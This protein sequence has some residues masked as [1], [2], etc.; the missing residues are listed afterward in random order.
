MRW[1]KTFLGTAEPYAAAL[2]RIAA[3]RWVVVDVETSGLD[4]SSDALLAIGAVA[5]R[6]QRVVVEDSF[7]RVVRQ[8]RASSRGNILIH[9]IGEQA[10]LG[11]MDAAEACR[12]FLD[13]AGPSPLV[14]FH[15]GF[16]RAFLARSVKLWLGLPLT[17]EWLDLAALAPALNP[18]VKAKALD[19]WLEHFGLSVDQ[20]HQASA[21]A[22]ATA[23]LFLRLLKQVPLAQ[24]SHAHLQR[25]ALAGRWSGAT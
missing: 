22:F 21:D 4:Q 20:R 6:H 23:M 15:S 3:Q 14:G 10:Q 8:H 13:Y 16:D 2:E 9:G 17:A 18:G 1:L 11:G 19:E 7:E 12:Q 25:L 5:I 24:R